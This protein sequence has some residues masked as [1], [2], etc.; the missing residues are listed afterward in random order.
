[1]IPSPA[2]Q[3]PIPSA[4]ASAP[5]VAERPERLSG[6]QLPDRS[7]RGSGSSRV[8]SSADWLEKAPPRQST[9]PQRTLIGAR[10]T[11]RGTTWIR[12]RATQPT[13]Q[14]SELDM[15]GSAAIAAARMTK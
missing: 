4:Q 6:L 12:T 15:K 9:R 8:Q 14:P 11:P 3:A 5:P 1:M 2:P 7:A 10:I 13:V